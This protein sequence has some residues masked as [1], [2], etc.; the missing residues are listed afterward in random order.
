MAKPAYE[1]TAVQA[2]AEMAAGRLSAAALAEA[3][4]A[5]TAEREA[6]VLGVAAVLT[7][8]IVLDWFVARVG[9]RLSAWRAAVLVG[10]VNTG[11]ALLSVGP[12]LL[13]GLP[14]GAAP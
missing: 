9:L 6:V 10:V 3:C 5:R 13:G 4:L 1:L 7:Y 14:A 8:S 12:H 2:L 11:A